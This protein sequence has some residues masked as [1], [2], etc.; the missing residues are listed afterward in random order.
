MEIILLKKNIFRMWNASPDI[1]KFIFF[2]EWHSSLSLP[3]SLSTYICV[4]V[5]PKDLSHTQK[6]E[7]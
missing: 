7:T 4:M 2:I 6:E 5:V 3:L 1:A